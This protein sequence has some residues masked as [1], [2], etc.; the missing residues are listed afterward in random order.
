MLLFPNLGVIRRYYLLDP[1][2]YMQEDLSEL[3]LDRSSRVA[4]PKFLLCSPY[5][6]LLELCDQHHPSLRHCNFTYDSQAQR[7]AQVQYSDSPRLQGHGQSL[8]TP[9]PPFLAIS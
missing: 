3:Y 6:N 2:A 8:R 9:L 4:W 5:E 7:Q 1:N